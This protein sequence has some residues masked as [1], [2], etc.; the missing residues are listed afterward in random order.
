M[1]RTEE[2]LRATFRRHAND[3]DTPT[4]TYD[5]VLNRYRRVRR[6]HVLGA[7]AAAGVLVLVAVPVT[8]SVLDARP[9]PGEVAGPVAPYPLPPRG[10]LADDE[11]FL[12]AV[13][14]APWGRGPDAVNPPL[15]TRQV[16]F[17]GEVAGGRWARVVG[18]IDGELVGAWFSGPSGAGGDAMTLRSEPHTVAT[19]PEVFYDYADGAGVLLVLSESGDR[20]AVSERPD[21]DAT[22]TVTRDYRSVETIDGVA[23]VDLPGKWLQ[24]LSVRI[25]RGSGTVFRGGIGEGSAEL[26]PGDQPETWTDQQIWEAANGALGIAPNPEVVRMVLD[27]LTDQAGYA[28]DELELSVLWAGPVGETEAV[29]VSAALPSGAVVVLGGRGQLYADGTTR[30]F[31]DLLSLHPSGTAAQDLMLV[32]RCDVHEGE[33]PTPIT[34]ELVVLGPPGSVSFR[35]LGP[36]PA[37]EE[38]GN[39]RIL[40]VQPVDGVTGVQA[41]DAAGNMIAEEPV[42]GVQDISDAGDGPVN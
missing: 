42:A 10:S 21:I 41:L 23:I 20:V 16:V 4:D 26:G 9:T 29:L 14:Q 32:M 3:V 37:V 15:N 28:V 12:A 39:G 1:T 8:Q 17:A 38:P 36:S 11:E 30:S 34:S 2:Q 35:L 22:G 13:V 25:D 24:A 40:S 7:A 33:G 6:L 31:G 27:P 19:G 18:Q 5:A